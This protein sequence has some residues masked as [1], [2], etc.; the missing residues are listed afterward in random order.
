M[1]S[2]LAL[3]GHHPFRLLAAGVVGRPVGIGYLVDPAAQAW[4]DGEVIYLPAGQ[5]AASASR[6][7]LVQCA[8]L[9][10]GELKTL[11]LRVLVGNVDLRRR[12]LV[13]EVARCCAQI[14]DRLPVSFLDEVA[15]Y[16]PVKVPASAA[17]SLQWAG[18][19]MKLPAP[20]EWYGQFKPWRVMRN[21]TSGGG[22][23][24]TAKQLAKLESRLSSLEDDGAQDE[25]EDQLHRNP[26][27]KLLSSPI[28]KDSFI[29]R[30]IRDIFDIRSSP[31][32]DSADSS[33]EGS[34]EMISGRSS[35]QAR[36]V[37]NAL[38][39]HLDLAIPSAMLG[40]ESGAH[41]YPEWDG[42]LGRYRPDWTQVEEVAPGADEPLFDTA[43]L[44]GPVD[45]RFQRALATLCLGFRR[46]RGQMQGEDLVLDP[47]V[48]LAVDLRTGHSG[49][50]RIYSA[51]L[52]TRRDLGVMILLDTSS[53]TLEGVG[54]DRVFERQAQVAW[55]LTQAFEL[56]GDRVA[57]YGFHSWGRTLVRFQ[58]LKTFDEPFGMG[59]RERMTRLS[60]AGYT[61]CGAAIRHACSMLD[62]HAGTPHKLLLLIS[63]G[64]PYDDQYEGA[65]ASADTR[66]A[67]EEAR[68][69]GVACLCVS[70]GSDADGARLADAYGKTNFIAVD[71]VPALIA[72]LRPAIE[73]AIA[74]AAR[75]RT[76]T[77]S[78]RKLA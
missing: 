38:R 70:V 35:R 57:L 40:A 14:A 68:T 13:L 24:T 62:A 61:R 32:G 22:R 47:L 33:A 46:H 10:G 66:K 52:R 4:T 74:S 51:S 37:A 54:S 21:A 3:H 29:A 41:S 50:E 34:S 39:S 77:E 26:F 67:L 76:T 78:G 49:D 6:Q 9:A 42:A 17:Q 73:N 27:L 23:K 56:L 45:R 19:R 8:L 36:D 65:H 53:S 43:V 15:P 63:D 44:A 2:N 69:H 31:G 1:R 30:A 75:T 28:G 7:L 60:V 72:R 25:N 5:S 11:G 64:Y 71:D 59:V 55:R 58:H 18:E 20:P 12:F 48:R 16:W